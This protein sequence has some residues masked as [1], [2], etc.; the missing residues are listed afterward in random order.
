M[1][2][3]FSRPALWIG[4]AAQ[5]AC[6]TLFCA[7]CLIDCTAANAN[8]KN[9]PAPSVAPASTAGELAVA[10]QSQWA[11]DEISGERTPLY[12]VLPRIGQWQVED[13]KTTWWVAYNQRLDM[14]LEAKLW[15]E[16]RLV[17]WQECR[18]DIQRWRAGAALPTAATESL[19]ARQLAIPD[20]FD[21]RLFV[22]TTGV[23]QA[24]GTVLLVGADVGHCFAFVATV[25]S[26]AGLSEDELL[27]RVALVTEGVVPKIRLRQAEER[28]QR[29]P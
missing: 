3:M 20:G 5:G 11:F 8:S 26:N 13:H 17:T 25:G 14:K 18:A 9:E 6:V 28:V 2:Q 22:T 10:R 4:P 19:E 23:Q 12:I 16:R 7:I 29:R 21:S 24:R 15:P 27:A 1:I